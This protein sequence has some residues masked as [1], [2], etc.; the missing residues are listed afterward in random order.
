M[1]THT[2][3]S[4]ERLDTDGQGGRLIVSE[5]LGRYLWGAQL[6][7]GLKVLDAGC[8][9]GYGLRILEAAGASRVVGVDLS[10]EAV[11]QASE[12]SESKRIEVLQG[13]LAE[14]PFSDGEFDL[15]VCFEVIEHVVEREAILDELMRVLGADGILCISTPNRRVY[16]PGNPHH[17]HEYEPEEFE[18]ALAKRF[19]HVLL[20]RQ[21]HGWPVR[22]CPTPSLRRRDQTSPSRCGRSRRSLRSQARRHSRLPL[23]LARRFP[24]HSPC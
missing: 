10:T 15:V 16:P 12:L 13:D 8:G 19:A 5:H 4:P 22:S 21:P 14:L 3:E 1:A 2:E 11:A 24:R 18:Q 6:A 20:H 7:S 9:T 23:P 17:V